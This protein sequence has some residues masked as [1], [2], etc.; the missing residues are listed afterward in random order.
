M[1]KDQ[2]LVMTTAS[3]TYRPT[4]AQEKWAKEFSERIRNEALNEVIVK[5]NQLAGGSNNLKLLSIE[6][7]QTNTGIK[8]LLVYHS[9]LKETIVWTYN[10]QTKKI[11]KYPPNCGNII[12][13]KNNI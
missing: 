7:S 13:R 12:N 9:F 5:F 3:N 1:K 2:E 4:A 10:K 6:D 8:L 11:S